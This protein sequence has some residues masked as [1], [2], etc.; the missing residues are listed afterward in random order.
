[1]NRKE[2]EAYKKLFLRAIRFSLV[3]ANPGSLDEA[4]FPAYAHKNPIINF[5]FWERLKKVMDFIEPIS[6]FEAS[7]DFGCGS[8][9][10]L[11]F[12]AKICSQVSAIDINI[13]PLEKVRQY[14]PFPENISIYD[15]RQTRLEDFPSSSFNVIF[16]L[17]VL[18]HVDGVQ[19]TLSNLCRLLTKTGMIIVSGPTENIIYKIGR[20]FAGTEYTGNYHFRNIFQIK[21]L[22][23]KTLKIKNIASLYHPIPF[24]EVFYGMNG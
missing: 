20:G 7:L 6:P 22:L 21:N 23:S 8:G 17:D 19:N 11:P 4:A 16:A 2:F 3:D 14:V 12:L 13:S 18:E 24:F 1:M 9:V 10:L 15:A 5:L